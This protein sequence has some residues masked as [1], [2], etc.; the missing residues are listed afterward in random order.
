M[1]EENKGHFSPLFTRCILV[2]VNT[3]RLKMRESKYWNEAGNIVHLSLAMPSPRQNLLKNGFEEDFTILS[4]T[5]RYIRRKIKGMGKKPNIV[6]FSKGY[7]W[8]RGTCL[9]FTLD[10]LFYHTNNVLEHQGSDFSSNKGN[11]IFVGD[12]FLLEVKFKRF[13]DITV[14]VA[15]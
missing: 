15:L 7:C 12:Y 8:H 5:D 3:T 11:R 6:V 9:S 10:V 2:F 4:L 1:T 13:S 14:C